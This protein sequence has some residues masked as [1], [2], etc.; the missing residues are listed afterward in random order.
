M[1][2]ETRVWLKV[3]MNCL[4]PCLHYT[5]IT[6]DRVCLVYALMTGM[7]INIGAIIKSSIRKA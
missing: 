5:D 2:Q 3:V 4:I 1:L 7:E 6:R